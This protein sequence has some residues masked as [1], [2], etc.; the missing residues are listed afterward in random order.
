MQLLAHEVH[1]YH[2]ACIA[3]RFRFEEAVKAYEEN[4]NFTDEQT[5]RTYLKVKEELILKRTEM[6]ALHRLCLERWGLV[7]KFAEFTG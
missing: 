5:V 6:E 1:A 7:A 3:E 2:M 4:L